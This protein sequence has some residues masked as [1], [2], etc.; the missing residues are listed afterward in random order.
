[1]LCETVISFPPSTCPLMS[2]SAFNFIYRNHP[3]FQPVAGLIRRQIGGGLAPTR[4]PS[5]AV[6]DQAHMRIGID[7]TL[8]EWHMRLHLFRVPLKPL[9]GLVPIKGLQLKRQ[10][11]ESRLLVGN[12]ILDDLVCLAKERER[13]A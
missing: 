3:P 12:D 11:C 8:L 7:E 13:I 5:K 4:L 6:S 1:M 2:A 10:V 9:D